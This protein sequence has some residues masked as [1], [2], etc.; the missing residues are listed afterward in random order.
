M[1]SLKNKIIGIFCFFLF[2]CI[3][4][5]IAQHKSITP[6]QGLT[7]EM[8]Y[9][10]AKRYLESEKKIKIK[11]L[12]TEKKFKFPP[13]FK[14]A[15]VDNFKVME[16]KSRHVYLIFD[17]ERLLSRMRQ[18]FE[19]RNDEGKGNFLVKGHGRG[20][21]DA[22]RFFSE[23]YSALT[24]KYGERTHESQEKDFSSSPI[25]KGTNPHMAI[26][27]DNLG[28]RMR[29]SVY[30]KSSSSFDRYVVRLQYSNAKILNAIIAEAEKNDEI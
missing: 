29:L 8:S 12:K 11:K 18:E 9:L 13:G 2:C 24:R 7:W 30:Y 5:V 1:K 15:K 22:W 23:L 19:W 17:D 16:Q 21:K 3:S 14:V 28:N 10:E 27:E 25:L 20:R 4:P 6:P 26:W